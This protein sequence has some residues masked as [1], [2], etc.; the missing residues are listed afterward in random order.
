MCMSPIFAK[1]TMSQG[2]SRVPSKVQRLLNLSEGDLI[3]W[4]ERDGELIF[5]KGDVIAVD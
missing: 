3:V 5:K 4:V 1:A 2:K